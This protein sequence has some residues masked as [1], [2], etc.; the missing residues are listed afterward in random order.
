M[1]D[2][3]SLKSR[4]LSVFKKKKAEDADSV[5]SIEEG[6]ETWGS[7]IDFFMSALGYAGNLNILIILANENWLC[8]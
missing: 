2:F 3:N 6:R 8:L 7:G 1:V 5:H 4:A